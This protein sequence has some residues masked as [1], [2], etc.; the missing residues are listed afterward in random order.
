[1]HTEVTLHCCIFPCSQ[2]QWQYSKP[3]LKTGTGCFRY[4]SFDRA[5]TNKEQWYPPWLAVKY[6]PGA[7]TAFA[8]TESIDRTLLFYVLGRCHRWAKQ[9]YYRTEPGSLVYIAVNQSAGE[10]PLHGN[11][12]RL[13]E[14]S[15]TLLHPHCFVRESRRTTSPKLKKIP[16][17]VVCKTIQPKGDAVTRF[18]LSK[19][20]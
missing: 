13:L 19:V 3:V 12:V 18:F 10:S 7:R 20:P 15:V 11:T 14:D 17:P 6:S 16:N 4:Y 2:R 1:M 8:V 5:L 9:Q